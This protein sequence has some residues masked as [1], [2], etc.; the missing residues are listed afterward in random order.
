MALSSFAYLPEITGSSMYQNILSAIS[1]QNPNLENLG[2]LFWQT[3]LTHLYT[4]F[5]QTLS[6][7]LLI[8]IRQTEVKYLPGVP[9][10]VIFSD[11][12]DLTHFLSKITQSASKIDENIKLA[13][14]NLEV[15]LSLGNLHW[16]ETF[17]Q[18]FKDICDVISQAIALSYNKA[19]NTCPTSA[20][21]TG[22][23][24]LTS[25]VPAK[26]AVPFNASNLK[27]QLQKDFNTL[28]AKAVAA[29]L[30]ITVQSTFE[31]YNSTVQFQTIGNLYW[32]FFLQKLSDKMSTC[33]KNDIQQWII[34]DSQHFA[35]PAGSPGTNPIL[36]PPIIPSTA[37]TFGFMM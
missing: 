33:L 9:A 22:T 4:D 27:T 5:T 15:S 6:N 21:A 32:A 14:A 18:I 25:P 36:I 17:I 20:L 2:F 29:D 13:C 26:I 19:T 10:P 30:T 8:Y 11:A 23:T 37:D 16:E 31:T 28:N 35:I 7:N 3:V 24:G 12:P 1:Q 34:T